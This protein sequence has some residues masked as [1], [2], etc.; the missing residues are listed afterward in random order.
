VDGSNLE[1]WQ[2]EFNQPNTGSGAYSFII[3]LQVGGTPN[4]VSFTASPATAK[5]GDVITV[6]WEV[7]N[8]KQVYIT[9]TTN[10]P[11]SDDFALSQ[12]PKGTATYTVTNNDSG[13]ITF[14]LHTEHPRITATAVVTL[15]CPFSTS[16]TKDCP[17]SQTTTQ[18][19][20][21]A[22]ENGYMFWKGDSKQIYVLFSGGSWVVYQDTW[23][24]GESIDLNGATPPDGKLAPANGFGKVWATQPGVRDKLGWAVSAESGY[25]ATWQINSASGAITYHF[26]LPDGRIVHLENTWSME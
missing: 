21:Q 15:T 18:A 6:S 22:F 17:G 14:V 16:L 11:A 8:S 3:P 4:I 26:T 10:Q 1:G 20:F 25:S 5:V 2:T 19:S 24:A 23:T 12:P 9:R 13:Q 7:A